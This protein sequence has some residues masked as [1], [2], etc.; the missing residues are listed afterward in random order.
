VTTAWQSGSFQ[1]NAFQIDS[2]VLS[3]AATGVLTG[4]GATLSGAAARAT[5]AVTHAATGTLAGAG[6]TGSAARSHAAVT[7]SATGILAGD[8]AIIVGSAARSTL[9][10][11]PSDVREGVHY[12]PGG[13]YVGT[14]T[15]GTG[16]A[17]I[18]L[19][20]FTEEH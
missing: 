11:D 4:G 20:S 10:P 15:V 2:A 3:H 12:G 13:I 16:T 5:G 7:H 8:G 14:L 1:Q 9:Y 19:R 17:I 18:R 6:A